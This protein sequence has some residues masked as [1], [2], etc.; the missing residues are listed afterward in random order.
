MNI[1]KNEPHGISICHITSFFIN[2]F[3]E[4]QTWAYLDIINETHALSL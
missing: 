2:E 1:Q 3:H 4:E